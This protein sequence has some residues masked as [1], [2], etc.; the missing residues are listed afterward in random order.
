MKMES[1]GVILSL[2]Y[3]NPNVEYYNPHGPMATQPMSQVSKMG[4]TCHQGWADSLEVL[5]VLLLLDDGLMQ[6]DA[7]WV[8]QF[9]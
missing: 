5:Q 7:G 8:G 1:Y 4:I 9:L 2:E 3:Y 6:I